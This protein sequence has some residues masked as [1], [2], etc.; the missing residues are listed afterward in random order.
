M[1]NIDIFL[2]D[3]AEYRNVVTSHPWVYFPLN[4]FAMVFF[5]FPTRYLEEFNG[6]EESCDDLSPDFQNI[7]QNHLNLVLR[8][9]IVTCFVGCF[10]IV[11]K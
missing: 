2:Q 7:L 1:G 3:E 8:F 6:N 9:C 4:Y 5:P 10:C 11:F